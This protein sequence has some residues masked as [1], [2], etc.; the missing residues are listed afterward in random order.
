MSHEVI[1]L[2]RYEVTEMPGQLITDISFKDCGI[3]EE[4]EIGQQFTARVVI[5]FEN[6]NNGALFSKM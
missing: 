4:E 3:R 5:A 1:L 2:F 6:R